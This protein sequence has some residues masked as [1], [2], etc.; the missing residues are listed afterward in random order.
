MRTKRIQVGSCN[1]HVVDEGTGTPTLFLHGNPDSSDIWE[2]ILPALAPHGRC[3]APDLPGFGRSDAPA[4]FDC[5]LDGMASF[6][7]R[8]VT[9]LGVTEPLN[10]VVHDIGG[11][12][13][14][15]WAVQ[16]PHKVRSIVIMNTVFFPDYRWH[17]MGRLWRMPVVGELVQAL[18]TRRGFVRELRRGSRRLTDA[19]INRTYD[20]VTAATK[21]MMLRWYRATDPRNFVLWEEGLLQLTARVPTLVLWGEHDPYIPARYAERFGTTNVER[22]AGVGHWLPAEAPKVVADRLLRFLHTAGPVTADAVPDQPRTRPQGNVRAA[23][24]ASW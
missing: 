24:I 22:F 12:Y 11:P 19:Q 21:R 16:Y 14:L 23:T 4:E 10:L 3:I 5:S 13:G 6:I 9:E 7:D 20:L 8:L 1:V 17:R 2:D 18:T 15:A